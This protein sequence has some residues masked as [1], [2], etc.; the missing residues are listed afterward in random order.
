MN[1]YLYPLSSVLF[2]FGG[3]DL[4]AAEYVELPGITHSSWLSNDGKTVVG[5]SGEFPNDQAFIWSREDSLRL[6]GSLPRHE[7]SSAWA[8]SGNGSVVVGASDSVDRFLDPSAS[9]IWTDEEG[10]REVQNAPGF[11]FDANATS[12]SAD[13]TVVSG[14]V[15]RLLPGGRSVF[16]VRNEAFRW[17]EE[18][19]MIA[20][21]LPES[22]VE[23]WGDEV[24]ADG[25]VVLV[26][27]NYEERRPSFS[28][29]SR[30]LLWDVENSFQ[31]LGSPPDYAADDPILHV[32]NGGLSTASSLSGDGSSMI[33]TGILRPDEDEVPR[34]VPLLWTKED[35]YRILPLLPNSIR[36]SATAITSDGSAVLGNSVFSDG[37]VR[38]F[39]WDERYGTRDLQQLLVDEHGL[40]SEDV[41]SITTVRDFSAD[42]S[43]LVGRITTEQGEGDRTWALFL[44]QPL[45]SVLPELYA[46]DADRDLDFDQLDLVKVQQA[47]KYLT[48]RDATWGEGDWNGAPGGSP[49][50][51]PEGDGV[52]DQADIV[53]ALQGN[54]YL[55]GPYASLAAAGIRGDGQTSLIYDTASGELSVDAPAGNKLTSIN[56]TSAAGLFQGDT[57]ALLDGAFDNFAA[58]NI[59]KATFGGTFGSISFGSVLPAGLAEEDLAADLSAVGSLAGGGALGEVDLIY[60]PEPTTVLLTLNGLLFLGLFRRRSIEWDP[61]D[62]LTINSDGIGRTD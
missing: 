10:M 56:V 51:P 38:P 12:I 20:L 24:S 42:G 37:S 14:T 15:S 4:S 19:G 44:D 58:D 39:V 50:R 34:R 47:A 11:D 30:L 1:R 45:V 35:G 16:D 27:A 22:A 21:G 6:L 8:V 54:T 18:E 17:T 26:K 55:T 62:T 13:G 43:T 40:N 46:G 32:S 9:F 59:F 2:L 53:A 36:G 57:P 60:V 3:A 33:A 23:S 7:R 29:S 61:G 28:P 49:N 31:E 41:A 52:F 25:N 48:G 5:R